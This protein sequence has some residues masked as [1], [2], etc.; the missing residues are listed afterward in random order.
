[1]GCKALNDDEKQAVFLEVYQDVRQQGPGSFEATQ[2]AF[3][4]LTDLSDRPDI[5]DIG[6]GSGR[7]TMDLAYLTD[8]S[9]VAVDNHPPFVETLSHKV[10]EKGLVDRIKVIKGDMK[11]LQFNDQSFDVIWAE[12]SIYHIGF[13]QGLQ[14]WQHL[15]KKGGYIV[16]SDLTWLRPDAPAEPKKFWYEDYPPMQDV[17]GNLQSIQRTGYGDIG[18]FPLPE[19]A[20]WNYYHPVEERISLLREKYKAD[21]EALD[22]IEKEQKEIDLY[23]KYSEYYGYVFY[24]A[25]LC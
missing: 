17:E 14:K 4:M 16:A 22:V 9:I 25:R 2:K 15:L 24:L 1:M 5:L 12:G 7:Q 18:H 13:E 20:W 8:G 19:S 3:S 23:R 6:C 11:D 21:T 10:N